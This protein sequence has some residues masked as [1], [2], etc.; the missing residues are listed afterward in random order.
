MRIVLQRVKKASVVV[1]GKIVS[2]IGKG[3]LVLLGAEKGDTEALADYLAKK[4][5]NLRIFPD[6]NDKM[7]LSIKDVV[8]EVLVV[9][10]FTLA[11]YIKKGNRPS[12]SDA[13]EEK[14]AEKLYEKFVDNI[15]SEG[16]R[17]RK[18][19]FKARM[20]VSLV[21]DGP[22]TFILERRANSKQSDFI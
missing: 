8:G 16:L 18:G 15:K 5:V 1:D 9:S 14:I 11:S 13:L 19:V 6:E 10:Q 22:V 17:V 20:E 12:F 4:I 2:E 3:L 7:N 21:N